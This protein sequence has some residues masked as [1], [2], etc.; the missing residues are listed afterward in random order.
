MQR[1]W[2]LAISALLA[3]FSFL[4]G[5][6][7]N[8]S[9]RFKEF[10]E[11][12]ELRMLTKSCTPSPASVTTPVSMIEDS[13]AYSPGDS[14]GVQVVVWR[15]MRNRATLLILESQLEDD[16]VDAEGKEYDLEWSKGSWSVLG[17]RAVVR[18]S[19]GRP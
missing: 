13:V 5:R 17:C 16:E 1:L 12:G 6:F 11:V 7:Y 3:A 9:F 15:R 18:Y 4:V 14:A 8:P 10:P 2:F 19:P